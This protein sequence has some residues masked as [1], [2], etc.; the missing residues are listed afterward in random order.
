M[1]VYRLIA[2]D[3]VAFQV[4]SSEKSRVGISQSSWEGLN[5]GQLC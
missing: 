3:D 1:Q 2:L 5:T 4:H